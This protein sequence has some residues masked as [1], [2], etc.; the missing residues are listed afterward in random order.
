MNTFGPKIFFDFHAW[1]KRC[2]FGNFSEFSK[3]AKQTNKHREKLFKRKDKV[4]YRTKS[5][6]MYHITSYLIHVSARLGR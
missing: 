2:H 6:G 4:L 1:V 3:I 5:V